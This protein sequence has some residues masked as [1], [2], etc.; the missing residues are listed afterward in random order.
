M[1]TRSIIFSILT[2]AIVSASAAKLSKRSALGRR[3]PPRAEAATAHRETTD[4]STSSG[5]IRHAAQALFGQSSLQASIRFH[6]RL[7]D[8]A[9]L[10]SGQ[11]LQSGQG[12]DFRSRLELR[13]PTA[14]RP[15]SLLEI[16]SGDD[17]WI[18]EELAEAPNLRRLD[19]RRLSSPARKLGTTTNWNPFVMLGGL[20][21]LLTGLDQSFVF[22]EI[23]TRRYKT[24]SVLE[25]EGK[26]ILPDS[27][28]KNSPPLDGTL[29]QVPNR[30][31]IYVGQSDLFPYFLEYTHQTPAGGS[32]TILTAEFFDVQFGVSI[33][34]SH[35]EFVP[36]TEVHDITDEFLSRRS[37]R[38][39]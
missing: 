21:G 17:L 22:R 2:V 6:V 30:V 36:Q 19:L 13:M 3:I 29:E 39:P 32:Q 20:P 5:R 7:F 33:D 11:Y 26:L 25:L 1:K 31:T 16:H 24:T 15:S 38:A 37:E 18:Y 14:A 23:G 35:F 12:E 34:P 8:Q 27:G 4:T 9:L 10:G 28:D